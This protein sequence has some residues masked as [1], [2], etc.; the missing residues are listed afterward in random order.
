MRIKKLV[1]NGTHN[2]KV[3]GG[4]AFGEQMLHRRPGELFLTDGV[5][6]FRRLPGS[7]ALFCGRFAARF[8][9]ADR[10]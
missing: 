6:G 5:V 3:S 9:D 10:G 1:K 2:S 8:S 4:A 7:P